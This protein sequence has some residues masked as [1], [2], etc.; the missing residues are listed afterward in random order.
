MLCNL[1]A[2]QLNIINNILLQK[3]FF[4]L[5]HYHRYYLSSNYFAG[6]HATE[7]ISYTI[8]VVLAGF[9]PNP[10][11][12]QAAAAVAMDILGFLFMMFAG[13][14]RLYLLSSLF[15]YVFVPHR[16]FLFP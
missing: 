9:L 11:V 15:I 6:M 10:D 8:L 7:F 16:H 12:Q 5:Q 13:D 2:K 3:Q 4:L 14:H 1:Y